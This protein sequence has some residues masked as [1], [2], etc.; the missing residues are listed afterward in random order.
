MY[1]QSTI[2][3]VVAIMADFKGD[4]CWDWPK[5]R[6]GAGYGQLSNRVS[7]RNVPAYAHRVAHFIA[8]GSLA[9]GM[10]V[11]HRCD[12]PACINPAHLFE[13]TARD[14]LQD[15]ASKGRSN[16]GKKLP[17]GNAHWAAQHPERVRGS[18]NGN[19]KLTEA[20]V[21]NIRAS[22]ER[23]ARLA[24]RYGVSQTLISGIRKGRRWPAV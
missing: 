2:D 21:R 22:E 1:Q 16:R 7:G 9:V 8:T 3:R 12:N 24:E 23:G 18:A 19:A 4:D 11:C 20:D 5:S 13:G 17:Q 10:D 6:T 14:N 15:M